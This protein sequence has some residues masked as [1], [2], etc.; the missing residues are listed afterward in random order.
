MV[1]LLGEGPRRLPE[2]RPAPPLATGRG[3]SGSRVRP[4]AAAWH[5]Q[6]VKGAYKA[7]CEMRGPSTFGIDL[8]SLCRTAN[9]CE[10]HAK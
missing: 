10:C 9:H 6:I 4:R 7:G 1:R 3:A 8:A 5:W 2:M